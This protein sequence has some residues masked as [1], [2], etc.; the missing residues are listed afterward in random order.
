MWQPT[1]QQPVYL[2]SF[3]AALPLHS[4][5][6]NDVGRS[7]SRRN[8]R[9][10]RDKIRRISMS[11]QSLSAATIT[12][13]TIT[14]NARIVRPS[15]SFGGTLQSLYLKLLYSSTQTSADGL[16]GQRQVNR[17]NDEKDATW[18]PFGMSQVS[19]RPESLV[20][21]LSCCTMDWLYYYYYYYI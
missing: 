2:T 16:N 17:M 20:V 3:D 9:K 15:H 8:R 4:K 7:I 10:Y 19:S 6:L 1:H 5:G 12:T 18:S 14:K 13:T 21:V 11:L